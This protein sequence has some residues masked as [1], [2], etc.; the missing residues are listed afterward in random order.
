[1]HIFL[2]VQTPVQVE[3]EPTEQQE[4]KAKQ[5]EEEPTV[6]YQQNAE[7]IKSIQESAR[8]IEFLDAGGESILKLPEKK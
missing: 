6:E 4:N 8:K 2:I 3:E 5:E 7:M 1:M